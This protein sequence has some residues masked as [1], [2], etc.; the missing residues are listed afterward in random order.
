MLCAIFTQYVCT[1]GAFESKL[2]IVLNFAQ[3][4]GLHGI[5][6]R[7]NPVVSNS[8][9]QENF[10]RFARH[11]CLAKQNVLFFRQTR[12]VTLLARSELN[13]VLKNG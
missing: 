9:K 12:L 11:F 6:G 10:S 4:G 7:T 8:T 1:S 2:V 3:I 13:W 5:K